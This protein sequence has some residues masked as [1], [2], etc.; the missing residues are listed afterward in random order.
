M[1]NIY[2]NKLKK[3]KSKYL[4]LKNE[5]SSEG[6]RYLF[7]PSEREKNLKIQLINE[8]EILEQC[9]VPIIELQNKL[10]IKNVSIDIINK[11]IKEL[12][13]DKKEKENILNI[14]ELKKEYIISIKMNTTFKEE[15]E[16]AI[17]KN[18]HMKEEKKIF[19]LFEEKTVIKKAINDIDM[20]KDKAN[21]N[22][23]YEDALIRTE[24]IK[25]LKNKITDIEQQYNVAIGNKQLSENEKKQEI[26]KIH[27][28]KVLI[29]ILSLLKD[30]NKKKINIKKNN[31]ETQLRE[32]NENN[33]IETIL[34][35][36]LKNTDIFVLQTY[37]DQYNK[38]L[39]NTIN[40]ITLE[41]NNLKTLNDEYNQLYN[42]YE[43]ENLKYLEQKN[44]VDSIIRDINTWFI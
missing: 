39:Q 30:H 10:D 35:E 34:Q 18:E 26:E 28:Q 23:N 9:R 6:G 32:L 36:I 16:K 4:K 25:I 29:T 33:K 2:E 7:F 44:I 21:E 13:I 1:N 15:I 22:K 38:L 3:Y 20:L 40:N 12:N 31:Y 42:N 37:Y 17:K 24:Q 41:N 43:K 19:I 11:K 8:K 14:I 5:Y 27:E